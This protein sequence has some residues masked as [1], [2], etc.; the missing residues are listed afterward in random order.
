M[1]L[2]TLRSII[3]GMELDTTLS[4]RESINAQ[5]ESIL[6]EATDPW[7]LKVTRVELK[8]IDP[9]KEIEEVMTKQMI[10]RVREI[11]NTIKLNTVL[12]PA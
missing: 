11:V 3:G 6:D 10:C 7:G 2:N 1:A 5:M 12:M 4:S 9:P 8:N